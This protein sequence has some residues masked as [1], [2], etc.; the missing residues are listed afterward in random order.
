MVR[1]ELPRGRPMR[2]Y[3][4]VVKE[5]IKRIGLDRGREREKAKEK[6]ELS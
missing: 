1:V 4:D 5:N 2:R 6:E 3:V